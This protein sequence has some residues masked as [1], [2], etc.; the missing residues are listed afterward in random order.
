MALGNA[1]KRLCEIENQSVTVT[2]LPPSLFTNQVFRLLRA[3]PCPVDYGMSAFDRFDRKTKNR[4]PSTEA[5]EAVPKQS[6]GWGPLIRDTISEAPASRL[7]PCGL[8]RDRLPGAMCGH[9]P[10]L[11]PEMYLVTL[12]LRREPG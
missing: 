11:Q 12:P 4:L 6:I 1:S 10:R 8:R 5:L 3:R 9:L 7:I 2:L